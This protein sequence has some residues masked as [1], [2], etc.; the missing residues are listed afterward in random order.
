MLLAI[1]PAY[2]DEEAI[3]RGLGGLTVATMPE[4][5]A[6][7]GV[8]PQTVQQGW[9][10]GGMPGENGKWPIAEIAIWHI[11]RRIRQAE[12]R[13]ISDGPDDDLSQLDLRERL[14]DVRT[15]ELRLSKIADE[16][17]DRHQAQ[18]DVST[19]LSILRENVLAVP[20]SLLPYFPAG[21]A[22]EL[23]E[24]VRR[25]LTHAMTA[26]AESLVKRFAH[27]GKEPTESPEIETDGQEDQQHDS[28]RPKR[29]RRQSGSGKQT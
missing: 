19:A 25:S 17:I 6:L 9:R 5:A 24:E 22:E 28:Q 4:V 15:K 26:A 13:R 18:A 11:R 16:V 1:A 20:R 14:A 8:S 2:V 10:Q 12:A 3:R 23:A 27:D 7:F 21:Q 29:S